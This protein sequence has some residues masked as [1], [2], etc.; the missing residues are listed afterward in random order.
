M[1]HVSL[2]TVQLVEA[3]S[4]LLQALSAAGPAASYFLKKRPLF[5]FASRK[6]GVLAFSELL[7]L[8]MPLGISALKSQLPLGKDPNV[9][10]AHQ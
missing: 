6:R 10:N 2:L 8:M 4:L 9:P 1:I 5:M 7:A 3:P